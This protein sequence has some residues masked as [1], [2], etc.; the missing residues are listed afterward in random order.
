[1]RRK[2]RPL[3][4]AIAV[5]LEERRLLRPTTEAL[6]RL[7][8][9]AGF[10][11]TLRSATESHSYE[12]V[13][14]TLR[15][16]G[17]EFVLSPAPMLN[18]LTSQGVCDSP[19]CRWKQA[20]QVGKLAALYSEYA[21]LTDRLSALL[22]GAD[23]RRTQ[24]RE[25]LFRHCWALLA[26]RKPLELGLVRMGISSFGLCEEHAK[27]IM[28]QLTDTADQ[29]TDEYKG[30]AKGT[31]EYGEL[32]L[33]VSAIWPRVTIIAKRMS[34]QKNATS[35]GWKRRVLLHEIAQHLLELLLQCKSAERL[36]SVVLSSNSFEL[37]ALR[38]F[39]GDNR[40]EEEVRK[41]E[42]LQSVDLPWISDLTL[43][44]TIVLRGEASSALPRLRELLAL[45]VTGGQAEGLSRRADVIQEL[46]EQTEEVRS[47]IAAVGLRRFERAETLIGGLAITMAVY[48]FASAIMPPAASLGTLLTALGSLHTVH[49]KKTSEEDSLRAKPAYALLKAQE[50]L[51]HRHDD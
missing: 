32:A 49:D 44:E 37:R 24:V 30:R 4:P 40:A 19:A 2:K 23:L 5:L 36:R 31:R 17:S 15:P 3:P 16:A 48:G 7:L 8:N 18:P 38:V 34:G 27:P 43:D 33:D 42:A 1:M 51:S 22:V 6:A 20:E 14:Q 28:K 26:L 50:I 10:R 13:D 46:R 9:D 39:D 47:E 29:L 45:R 11:K 35:K 25:E 41:W 12:Y 21:V